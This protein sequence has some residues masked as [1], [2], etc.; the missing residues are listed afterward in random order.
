M[1]PNDLLRRAAAAAGSGQESQSI[2]DQPL[3]DIL[4]RATTPGPG[5]LGGSAGAILS[6]GESAAWATH[7]LDH[8]YPRG[9]EPYD[10]DLIGALERERSDVAS[11]ARFGH[12]VTC[13]SYHLYVAFE[14]ARVT[15][16]ELSTARNVLKPGSGL[17][18][19]YSSL[20]NT[21][22]QRYRDLRLALL[23]SWSPPA[24]VDALVS[25]A[26]LMLCE[27]TPAD[28]QLRNLFSQDRPRAFQELAHHLD[29]VADQLKA[30]IKLASDLEMIPADDPPNDD[31]MRLASVQAEI[32]RNAGETLK[33]TEAAARVGTT[34]QALHKR[35]RNGS[36]LG[37]MRG[38]EL[39][40]PSAQFIGSKEKAQVVDGLSPIVSLFDSS[41]AG[42]WSVLQ[43]LTE[44]DPNLREAPLNALKQ[45]K[46]DA[47][48]KAARAYLSLDEA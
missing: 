11:V 12:R 17:S 4:L 31:A 2:L 1:V 40:V 32:L 9:G 28:S 22:F 42:R 6:I 44:V 41:G 36:A 34:R 27:I 30:A 46:S 33:L 24:E 19:W 3:R 5:Y 37:L 39:V 45:G 43:F 10:A 38:T 20:V 14:K 13:A 18:V 15:D 47:V 25:S 48:I 8:I 16:F 23:H 26:Y 35:I 21:T 7:Y 29:I